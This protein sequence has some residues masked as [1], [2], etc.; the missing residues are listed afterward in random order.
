MSFVNPLLLIRLDPDGGWVV[1]QTPESAYVSLSRSLH[2][3][4]LK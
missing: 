4:A 2:I 3:M 1:N